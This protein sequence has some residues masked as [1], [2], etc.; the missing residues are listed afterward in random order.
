M[1]ETL[2]V[3]GG[4]IG[5]ATVGL[6]VF[7]RNIRSYSGRV[8]GLMT[9]SFI[10]LMVANAFTFGPLFNSEWVLLCIRLVA[11][12]TAL[13][14]MLLYVLMQALALDAGAKGAKK[15]NIR[16]IVLVSIIIAAIN[17]TPF[18][19]S[20][21]NIN[22]TGVDS[23]SVGPAIILF[24]AHSGAMVLLTVASLWKGLHHRSRKRRGQSVS[25]LI[26]VT[27]ALAVAPVTSF[28]LPVVFNQT[29]FVALSP[30]Y[31][32]FFIVMVAYAMIRHGLF[33]IRL[34]AVRTAAYGLSLI[35]LA[36]LYV[37]IVSLASRIFLWKSDAE[38]SSLL[39]PVAILSTLVVA[40]AFQPIQKLFNKLTDK[41]FYKDNYSVGRFI[42]L[43]NQT[44]NST[45]DLR[46]LLERVSLVI[47]K[48]LKS[49]QV[50]F[51]V[52]LPS[53]RYMTAGTDGH[54]KVSVA[55]FYAQ[56]ENIDFDTPIYFASQLSTDNPL[57]R[58]MISHKVEILVPL[59]KGGAVIGYM[60][61][62][63]PMSLGYTNRDIRAIKT[64]VGELTIAIQNSLSVEE[65]RKLNNTL[66]QRIDAA[67]KE[68]RASNAQLQRLDEAKDE[69]ISMASHQLRTPLTS[70][71]GYISMLIEGDV[72]PVTKDQKKLLSEAFISSERMVHLIGDFLN[73]S[74]LQTGK[75][76]VDK[77]AVDINKLVKREVESLRQSAL[78]RGITFEYKVIGNIP[79]VEI[80]ENKIQ[81]VVMNFADNAMYYSKEG[82]KVQITLQW[83]GNFVEL[84]VI[85]TGIGIPEKE[86]SHLFNKFFRAANARRVRPDGTGVGLFLAKRVVLEHGGSII[87]ESKEGEGSTFGFRLPALKVQSKKVVNKNPTK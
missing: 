7:L 51:F 24:A 61:L 65:V 18:V 69:F 5:A 73:V 57:R 2:I 6:F 3:I 8:Y 81:Q 40:L 83:V 68:L 75:F 14:L 15:E 33:D 12:F 56:G 32:S 37:I 28:L 64:L 16:T 71:K 76:M 77:R 27:P 74:R 58:M 17:A 34:A 52:H 86:Q 63:D 42:S 70:I 1:I 45:N 82:D 85:D 22:D 38:F 19:F 29:G 4:V 43:I 50:F 54:S 79:L 21:V 62:G 11:V 23:V 39:S 44:L 55:D 20:G 84:R 72:G 48:T 78:S 46:L 25:I 59:R 87:F 80:D 26:G 41:L 10:G 53:G 60:C 67:T 49:Q 30:L 9:L 47:G 35:T 13:A 31:I 36:F 66:E